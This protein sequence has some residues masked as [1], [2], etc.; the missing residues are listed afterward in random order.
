MSSRELFP[1]PR[2]GQTCHARRLC[3]QLAAALCFLTAA[4]ALADKGGVPQASITLSGSDVALCNHNNTEWS[5]TK[6]VTDDDRMAHTVTWTVTATRGATSDNM[7]LANGFVSVTNTGTG[8]ATI[9]NIVVNLQRKIGAK[10]KSASVDVADATH[11]DAATKACIVAAA[12]D[13]LVVAGG[14]YTVS[15]AKGT[16]T[17]NAASGPLEFTDADSNTLF[18]LTPQKTLQPGETVNLFYTAQFDN[19]ILAIPAGEHVRIEFIISFGNAGARGGSGASVPNIDINGNGKIDPDEANVRS[20]PTRISLPLPRLEECNDE[21]LLTDIAVTTTHTVTYDEVTFDPATPNW[22][23]GVLISATTSFKVIA[24]GVDGGEDGGTISNTATLFS[25]SD[26]VSVIIGYNADLTPIYHD[27]VCCVGIDLEASDSVVFLGG[28][29]TP[30]DFTTYAQ[31]AYGQVVGGGPHK[32]EPSGAPA[33]L[34]WTNF[35]TVYPHGIEV[36]IPGASGFSMNFTSPAKVAAYLPA[37]GTP[38]ELTADLIDPTS[39]SAGVFGGQV[40]TL[41]INVDFSAADVTPSGFGALH[42]H[43]TG[44]S[45]DGLTV[46]QILAEANL[47]LGGDGPPAGFTFG[48]LNDLITKLN[49]AFDNGTESA[50]AAAH[51]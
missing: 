25:P 24:S 7:I 43:D 11:G 42:L 35:A 49:E 12:S 1:Q 27:F 50:W 44:T 26:S 14:P 38:D 23:S 41:Q 20:V 4:P 48:T 16:F 51:L 5:L 47:A 10:W 21:V 22:P 19:T 33:I 28:G 13:T 45:L 2:T 30:G 18:S 17:E 34:F 39:T 31:G 32:G 46:S 15:G 36:G 8:K 37:G 6:K 9:G 3:W 29:N 40:L